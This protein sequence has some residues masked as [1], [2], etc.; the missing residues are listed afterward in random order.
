MPC[1]LLITESDRPVPQSAGRWLEG[2]IC[3]IMDEPVTWG[4]GELDISNF[5][6]FTVTDR[7]ALEMNTY[8]TTY[9][10]DYDFTLIAQNVDLRRYEVKNL[11]AN[12]L[13]VGYWTQEA[14]DAIK[15]NWEVDHPN[16]DIT[17]I[18]FPNQDANG[19]GNIWDMSGEFPAGQGAE[20]QAVVAAAGAEHMDKRKEWHIS[21]AM[22]QNIRN[23]GGAQSGTS[24]QLSPNLIDSRLD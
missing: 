18:G 23:A 22:M 14:V 20:F 3:V 17:T 5:V 7:T 2:E 16:A 21:S 9:V 8:L 24:A 15:T 10:R 12:T 11:F 1:T 6:R 19:L 4:S 13:G